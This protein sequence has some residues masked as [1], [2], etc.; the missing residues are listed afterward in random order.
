MRNL[1]IDAAQRKYMASSL[2]SKARELEYFLNMMKQAGAASQ[3]L[4]AAHS[5]IPEQ[6]NHEDEEAHRQHGRAVT[7]GCSAFLNAVLTLKDAVQTVTGEDITSADIQSCRHGE[8]IFQLRNAS[9]HD[10]MPTTDAWVEGKFYFLTSR[11]RY[12]QGKNPNLITL[13]PP[14]I[15]IVTSSAEFASDWC[16]MLAQR[17]AGH[18][19]RP[20]LCGPLFTPEWLDDAWSR[21]DILPSFAVEIYQ[22]TRASVH[23]NIKGDTTDPITEAITELSHISLVNGETALPL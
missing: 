18:I 1:A 23:A 14:S 5:T 19:G 10:G 9:T 21:T 15:D 7:F 3:H 13:N 16:A 11:T 17:L 6:E 20:E 12:G 2:A 4:F 22:R 8:F